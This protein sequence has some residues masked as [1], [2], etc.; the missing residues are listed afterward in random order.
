MPPPANLQVSSSNFQTWKINLQPDGPRSAACL[1]A[2]G[3][4]QLLG[5]AS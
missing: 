1:A 5:T 3:V 4:A 2:H